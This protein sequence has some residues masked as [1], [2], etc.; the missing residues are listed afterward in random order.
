MVLAYQCP[1]HGIH[2]ECDVDASGQ[3]ICPTD[4][5]DIAV[6]G[7][8]GSTRSSENGHITGDTDWIIG[9]G[10]GTSAIIVRAFDVEGAFE[11]AMDQLDDPT[12]TKIKPRDPK[13]RHT[14]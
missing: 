9:V 11:A 5:S 3:R 7:I 1:D 8:T 13:Q 2:Y 6:T 10:Y 4:E 12:I 14:L